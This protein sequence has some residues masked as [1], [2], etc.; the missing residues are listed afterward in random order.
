M[1]AQQMHPYDGSS[2]PALNIPPA[3]F[4]RFGRVVNAAAQ[5]RRIKSAA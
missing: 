5:T 4:G 3:T 2:S 1:S